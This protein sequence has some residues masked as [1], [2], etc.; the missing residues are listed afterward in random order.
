MNYVERKMTPNSHN[1]HIRQIINQL[2]GGEVRDLDAFLLDYFSHLASTHCAEIN[3][4]NLCH[5]LEEWIDKYRKKSYAFIFIDGFDEIDH[6]NEKFHELKAAAWVDKTSIQ[7]D[8]CYH[9]HFHRAFLEVFNKESVGNWAIKWTSESVTSLGSDCSPTEKDFMLIGH[10][11]L[12]SEK[13]DLLFYSD[14]TILWDIVDRLTLRDLPIKSIILNACH[15]SLP[16]DPPASDA[17]FSS[18]DCEAYLHGDLSDEK[19][20]TFVAHV[21]DCAECSDLLR[22]T[23]QIEEALN[24]VF[25]HLEEQ[26]AEPEVPP[27]LP[28][29]FVH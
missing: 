11:H 22:T 7:Q 6:L 12:L 2:F 25:E 10:G 26:D 24:E 15:S 19:S 13:S 29:G 14:K 3:Q 17:H 1:N 5:E 16:A 18:E 8:A 4:H 21:A 9:K 20:D 23:A 28:L 27:S